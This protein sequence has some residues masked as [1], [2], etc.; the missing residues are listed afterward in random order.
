VSA[1]VSTLIGVRNNVA[2]M[3]SALRCADVNDITCIAHSLLLVLAH[4][5]GR[6]NICGLNLTPKLLTAENFGITTDGWTHTTMNH[7]NLTVG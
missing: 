5:G 2:N 6:A 1:L 3:I 4:G 7:G